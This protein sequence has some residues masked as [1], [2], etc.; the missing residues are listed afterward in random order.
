M[1]VLPNH[2]LPT[3][4]IV[5]RH[6]LLD[7]LSMGNFNS[8]RMQ[9]SCKHGFESVSQQPCLSLSLNLTP[10][11]RGSETKD[12]LRRIRVFLSRTGQAEKM[13][14]FREALPIPSAVYLPPLTDCPLV[15]ILQLSLLPGS[16][17]R[18]P[19]SHHPPSILRPLYR[20]IAMSP[21]GR[22]V[23]RPSE[24]SRENLEISTSTST[25]CFP[26]DSNKCRRGN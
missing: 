14:M 21:G 2:Q 10:N 7:P 9:I 5:T 12:H 24:S 19:S 17:R 25:Q 22:A 20:G 11:V 6:C 23:Q 15:G 18:C 13:G 26:L 3:S 4:I 8:A 1:D 16:Q